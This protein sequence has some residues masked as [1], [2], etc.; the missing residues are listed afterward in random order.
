MK[1]WTQTLLAVTIA[2]TMSACAGDRAPDANTGDKPVGTSG[3]V[4]VA[5]KDA[6]ADSA[7][8]AD[9]EFV[10]DMMADGRA[11]IE[12]GKLAQQK[13]RNERVKAFASTMVRDHQRAGAELKDIAQHAN[14]DM[15]KSDVDMDHGNDTRQRLS[16]LSGM[17][18][19]REYL[20]AMIDD[21]EKAVDDLEDRAGDADSDHVKQWAAKTL[22]TVKK[23]LEEAK[24]I[25]N[26]LDKISGT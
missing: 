8:R 24:E 23:H 17:E 20:S 13:A 12:L 22:P 9:R 18:F 2:A 4:A 5:G 1:R 21:H 19:D 3:T 16:R 26:H 6:K 11:E 25:K 7:R 10:G 15:P 14:I